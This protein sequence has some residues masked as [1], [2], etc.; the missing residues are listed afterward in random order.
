MA[1][2]FGLE[3]GHLAIAAGLIGPPPAEVLYAYSGAQFNEDMG[4]NELVRIARERAEARKA[5]KLAN[6][7][8]YRRAYFRQRTVDYWRYFQLHR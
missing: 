7:Q 6:F 3:F 5:R 4:P 1:I 2:I 8:R